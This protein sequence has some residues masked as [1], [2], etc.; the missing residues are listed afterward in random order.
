M[1]E[2]TVKQTLQEAYNLFM[3][4]TSVLGL[5]SKKEGI[6][7]KDIEKLIE[8]RQKARKEKNFELSDKIRD[9]LKEKGIILEDTPQGVKWRRM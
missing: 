3:E 5:L 9:D 2:K 4:L 1:D 6:L 7:E 8:K